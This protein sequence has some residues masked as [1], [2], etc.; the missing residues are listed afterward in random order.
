MTFKH[1]S[2]ISAIQGLELRV[3]AIVEGFLSGLHRSPFHGFSVEFSE[4]RNYN[5]GD[6]IRYIDW[7]VYG[8]TEKLMIKKYEAETNLSANIIYD[9]S[10]SMSY[11]GKAVSKLEYSKNLASAIIYILSRQNDAIGLYT[12]NKEV[13]LSVQAKSGLH[14]MNRVL[15][16]INSLEGES[17]TSISEMIERLERNITKKGLLIFFTDLLDFD[18]ELLNKFIVLKKMGHDIVV[19]HMM[20][21]TESKFEFEGKT[22]FIDLE[23]KEV[24]EV[25]PDMVKDDYKKLITDH[26]K[27]IKEIFYKNQI[28]Y[29][30]TM[31]S[32][33]YEEHLLNFLK[34]RQKRF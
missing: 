29:F 1:P 32:D 11:S 26:F 34:V 27:G 33:F 21:E 20:D 28:D 18:E 2:E 5:F 31:T 9:I 14:H 23:T 22:R 19:F 6:P 10:R 4:F 8:K 24:I 16:L 3:K 7:K 13:Q 25:Y 15:Q 30:S 17:G 12:F